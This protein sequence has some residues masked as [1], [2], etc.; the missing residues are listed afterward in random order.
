MGSIPDQGTK[1]P[2]ATQHSQKKKNFFL[3]SEKKKREEIFSLQQV[4][5]GSCVIHILA[6]RLGNHLSL[7]V[8]HCTLRQLANPWSVSTSRTGISALEIDMTCLPGDRT[9]GLATP[10]RFFPPTKPRAYPLRVL[11]LTSPFPPTP[12]PPAPGCESLQEPA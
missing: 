1:I 10:M 2:R 11:F 6:K 8:S 7:G 5:E 4:L 9:E 12:A 3:I